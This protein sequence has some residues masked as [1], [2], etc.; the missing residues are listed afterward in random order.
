[1][2]NLYFLRDSQGMEADLVYQKNHHELIPMEIKSSLTWTPDFCRNLKKIQKLSEKIQ[3][4]YVVYA[5]DLTPEIDG[6]TFVNFRQMGML[7]T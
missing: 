7:V 6:V 2:P 4:G 5:G 3:P 1:M